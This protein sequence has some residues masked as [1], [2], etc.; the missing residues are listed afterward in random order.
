MDSDE[1][2]RNCI[3]RCFQSVGCAPD[4]NAGV[5]KPY[6]DLIRSIEGWVSILPASHIASDDD[7]G[8]GNVHSTFEDGN[9]NIAGTQEDL[10]RLFVEKIAYNEEE[11]AEED[12]DYQ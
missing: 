2:L 9:M 3:I 1:S 12:I 8:G 5:H 7:D 11:E 6:K 10:L 4:P